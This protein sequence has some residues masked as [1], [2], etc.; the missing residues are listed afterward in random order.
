MV[1]VD[2]SELNFDYIPYDKETIKEWVKEHEDVVKDARE[3]WVDSPTN[4]VSLVDNPA[5][6]SQFIEKSEDN[7]DIKTT[8]RHRFVSK[9]QSLLDDRI[10]YA[11]AM[12]SNRPDR[13]GDVVPDFS[14]KDSAHNF[15]RE[16]KNKEIDMDHETPL[17][18]D[19]SATHRATVVESWILSEDKEL[20]T[21]DGEKTVT[22]KE[23]DW[24]LGLY[25]EDDETLEQVRK[26]KKKGLSVMARPYPAEV[27]QNGDELILSNAVNKDMTE[28]DN[29][30]KSVETFR[31][32][33]K[34]NNV[35]ADLDEL[36][37]EEMEEMVKN[38]AEHIEQEEQSTEEEE[39]EA[40]TEETE[41][42]EETKSIADIDSRLDTIEE[43][44]ESLEVQKEEEEEEEKDA[45]K[46]DDDDPCW[47]GY[48]M[49]GMDENGDPKC[50]PKDEKDAD[51]TVMT[52]EDQKRPDKKDVERQA[53]EKGHDDDEYEKDDL[54]EGLTDY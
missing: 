5:H 1:T 14:V 35:D 13:E 6:P 44:L 48:E 3:I 21:A 49:I 26:G 24:M 8:D 19:S 42:T 23:G 37:E 40:E 28:S 53:S 29:T 11:P 32:I 27:E 9:S 25:L 4:V 10:V 7:E 36:S 38:I 51:A 54:F 2:V 16:N 34:A 47:E 41:D 30:E 31:T 15:M 17:G 12:V 43:K 22:Y 33:L 52:S 18:A 50:V 20:E 45:E 39:T 46:E